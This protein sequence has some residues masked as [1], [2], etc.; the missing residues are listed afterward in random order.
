MHIPFGRAKPGRTIRRCAAL[1][2]ASVL[3]SAGSSPA[4]ALPPAN[5]DT[6]I[7]AC[8]PA[9][10]PLCFVDGTGAARGFAVDLLR[11]AVS[12][13]HRE[14][15]FRTGP[16]NEIRTLLAE[17]VIDALPLVGRTP[18]RETVFDFTFPYLSLHG[19]LV[20]R[21]GDEDI[22]TLEDL[23]GR[24][25]AVMEGDNAEEFIRR[26]DY[27]CT[28]RTTSTFE[29][30]LRELSGGKHD[31]VLMQ[32]L[33][34]VRLMRRNRLDNL[35]IPGPPVE[36]FRQD[37]CFAVTEGDHGMLS[38][39]NEGLAL[40][41]ADG[42]FTRLQ[43][44]WIGS[45]KLPSD[46]SVLVATE[47]A[48]PPYSFLDKKGK[49][50]GFTVDL[51]QATSEITGMEID[52]VYKPWSAI[53]HDLSRGHIDAVAGMFYSEERDKEFEFSAPFAVVHHAVFAHD[54]SPPV[55]SEDDL[56][57]KRLIVMKD[58][59]MHD[60]VLEHNLT[61]S[62]TVVESQAEAIRLL[63]EKNHDFALLAE[64]PGL[65]WVH[66]LEAD[67]VTMQLSG[68]RPSKYCFA[69]REENTDLLM[70][71]NEGLAILKETNRYQALREKWLAP[72]LG[73]DGIHVRNALIALAI[74]LVVLAVVLAWTWSLRKLVRER[75]RE[76]RREIA[77]RKREE[78]E[79]ESYRVFL[80][81][82]Q[83]KTPFPM[84]V[85][86]KEGTVIKTNRALRETINL[87]DDEIVGKYNVLCD[88]NLEKQGV[89]PSVEAVF[90]RH[91]PARFSIPWSAAEAGD[92]DFSAGRDMI[93]DVALYPIRSP[94]GELRY[95][96][97]QWIDITRR[98]RAQESL[99]AE[100]E[101]LAV[102]LRSIGDGVITTDVNGRIVLVNKVAETLT[103]WRQEEARGKPLP[104]VFHIVNEIS[105]QPFASPVD[106]VLSSGEVI[107]LENHTM[108]I[109]RDGTERIIAD[110][111]APIKDSRSEVV[112]V[113]LVFRDM[114]EKRRMR[115]AMERA[116]R[117]ESL[118]VLAGGI[119][120]DFNNLLG[121][122]YGY[123][124]MAISTT[125]EPKV[126]GYLERSMDTID[127]TRALTSQLL[128]FSKGGAP[129]RSVQALF[130]FIQEAA[131]FALS[132][133]NVTSAYDIA[134]DLRPCS[135]DRNQMGQVI[136]NLVINAQQAMPM[137]GTVTI[138]ARN[139]RLTDA[140]RG[141]LPA[142][143]YVRISVEDTGVG[144]PADMLHRVFDPFFSTK[145]KG[146][147]LGLATSFSII[148]QH[149]GRIEV[150][151]ESGKGTTFHI[152]LP[153]CGA[154]DTA[155]G[156]ASSI[157]HRGSGAILVMDDE[158]V[159]RDITRDMLSSMG[160]T[161]ECVT[162]GTA[163]LEAFEARRNSGDP[164]RAAI[165]DLTIPG[166]AGGRE[167]IGRVREIDSEIPVFV[168]SGFSEDPV[169]ANPESY[170]FTASVRKPF[171]RSELGERLDRFL[172]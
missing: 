32:Q 58:D 170:G 158:E 46:R 82:I 118:G 116:D 51:V 78:A 22:R 35:R 72:L 153:G 159:M 157:T 122:I 163:A 160:Y 45:D 94:D 68:L 123:I 164:F 7:S 112:G 10:P 64:L 15:T 57:G 114:T 69:V 146:H 126:A 125:G 54:Q 96:V 151:S 101:R 100:R 120:H 98:T 6:I 88:A 136:D 162:D 55:K 172:K 18:E 142:G 87:T 167:T 42:T 37:F 30:A 19:A 61:D 109:A 39:L 119:A 77:E 137:G 47:A 63:A 31:A 29:E 66:E 48:Y 75:T 111:G 44:R 52:P 9:Y 20:V 79:K 95:V 130:P 85:A 13:M 26:G 38:V 93:I 166:G 90:S 139:V 107:E 99:A 36:E 104:E 5:S 117:L 155:A 1:L 16:W 150:E 92:V 161:V 169:M 103:G 73:P 131:G 56:R 2:A 70:R 76:L 14:A 71:L 89:M 145:T 127:R 143:E 34:A 129:V 156:G 83:E 4:E 165:F 43:A 134:T 62:P 102:T 60:Y 12:A 81:T 148:E 168:A 115:R 144:I 91:E 41:I 97:C 27:G 135:I 121:G 40:V 67:N 33:L 147:G 25:V 86:D 113:V 59:I 17:D 84:W 23:E 154:D 149:G 128:T 50:T 65:H 133:S 8:E 105:E 108:L 140:D 21:E 110:S 24:E 106:R 53:R 132:G 3:L 28:V 49:P 141:E 11:A 124:D 152:L 80:E 138:R 74:L 171:R